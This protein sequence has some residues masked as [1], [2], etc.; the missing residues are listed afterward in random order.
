[1]NFGESASARDADPLG[2]APRRIPCG[3]RSTAADS[4]PHRS[5]S[6]TT[7]S[8]CAARSRA[9]ALAVHDQRFGDQGQHLHHPRVQAPRR[10]PKTICISRA[11]APH[12]P[13]G[14]PNTPLALELPPSPAA[15]HQ[16]CSTA[17]PTVVFQH[18]DS[19][20]SPASRGPT[21]NDTRCPPPGRLPRSAPAARASN[22]TTRRVR[23]AARAAAL[24]SCRARSPAP[25]P[26]WQRGLNFGRCHRA[27]AYRVT[28]WAA[29][30]PED[31]RS[32]RSC[33]DDSAASGITL[34]S[35]CPSR[36]PHHRL[37]SRRRTCSPEPVILHV[38]DHHVR[39]L[40]VHS[41][42]SAT[43]GTRR[44]GAVART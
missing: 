36:V 10:V 3:Y 21:S 2:A 17:R 7:R 24:R 12:H 20:T 14:A 15:P 27:Q 1:M 26:S 38:V 11:Q 8:P 41:T 31:K 23:S 39:V 42:P 13:Q 19:P 37:C 29:Q 32:S 9:R 30:V 4:S 40:V 6:S 25:R 28:A 33:N 16:P 34:Y 18:P 22:S 35:T 5:S 44:P 43:A